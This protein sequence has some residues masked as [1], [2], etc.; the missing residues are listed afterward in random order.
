MTGHLELADAIERFARG[1]ADQLTADGSFALGMAAAVVTQVEMNEHTDQDPRPLSSTVA[2]QIR[3]RVTRVR[4][5]ADDTESAVGLVALYAR[6]LDDIGQL[7]GLAPLQVP[8]DVAARKHEFDSADRSA[9]GDGG[10]S[11][12]FHPGDGRIDTV[13]DADE[14]KRNTLWSPPPDL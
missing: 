4:A 10:W 12:S 6:A 3:R 5:E 9:R 8:V 2:A 11:T 13:Q 14:M 7:V 1:H